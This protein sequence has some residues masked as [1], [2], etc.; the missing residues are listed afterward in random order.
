MSH[1]RAQ[2][3]PV[4]DLP[5]SSGMWVQ[6]LLIEAFVGMFARPGRT[7]LTVLGTCIGLAALVATFASAVEFDRFMKPIT[8][9]REI[10]ISN[11]AARARSRAA[12]T[13][14][15]SA[16]AALM[17]SDSSR[18][19]RFTTSSIRDLLTAAGA[20]EP[21]RCPNL[22]RSQEAT[23]GAGAKYVHMKDL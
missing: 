12:S 16:M 23:A 1:S 19:N 14:A 3:R 8:A 22:D 13:L 9:S 11:P 15:S 7:M 17:A 20:G 10:F 2:E 4:E 18:A 21:G 5:P 6:D